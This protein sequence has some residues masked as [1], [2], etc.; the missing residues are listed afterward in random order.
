MADPALWTEYAG[1][2]IAVGGS[3]VT[4]AAALV[5]SNNRRHASHEARNAA[6]ELR[7][8]ELAARVVKTPD[9]E[10]QSQ[11]I[12][13]ALSD[14]KEE[15]LDQVADLRDEVRATNA[16]IDKAQQDE[17]NALRARGLGGTAG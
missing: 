11:T 13:N 12:L 3:A 7:L 14:V 15:V 10:R 9:L 1:L 17:I 8:A 2:A 6:Q 16:R 4:G 5:R